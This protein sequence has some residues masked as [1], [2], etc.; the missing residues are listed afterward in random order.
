MTS[1]RN[2]RIAKVT[3]N[4]GINSEKVWIAFALLFLFYY[5]QF[6]KI[7]RGSATIRLRSDEMRSTSVDSYLFVRH[8][9]I[10]VM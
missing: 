6:N 8:F 10:T 1:M 2:L 7:F 9:A 5:V 3:I 4:C